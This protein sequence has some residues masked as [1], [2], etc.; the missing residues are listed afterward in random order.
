MLSADKATK[1]DGDGEDYATGETST[2]REQLDL[3]GLECDASS[4]HE[5]SKGSGVSEDLSGSLFP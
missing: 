2:P 3:S 4:L 1:H 5:V